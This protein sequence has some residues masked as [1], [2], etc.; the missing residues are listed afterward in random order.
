[1]Y[2]SYI[3]KRRKRQGFN[4]D[5]S[6]ERSE[7]RFGGIHLVNTHAIADKVEHIFR[8]CVDKERDRATDK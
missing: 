4:A 6:V 1:M 8:L 7:I 2:E 5:A 3:R